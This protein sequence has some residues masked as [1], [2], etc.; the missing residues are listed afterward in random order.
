MANKQATKK[1]NYVGEVPGWFIEHNF[2]QSGTY[3]TIILFKCWVRALSE[4]LP[5]CVFINDNC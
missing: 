2:I 4:V 3:K 1:Q 5:F